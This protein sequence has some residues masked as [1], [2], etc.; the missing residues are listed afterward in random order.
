MLDHMISAIVNFTSTGIKAHQGLTL[1]R[2]SRQQD[3][4]FY[5][6]QQC[7]LVS[8]VSYAFNIKFWP[9]ALMY[10]LI[11]VISMSLSR[12]NVF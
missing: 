9:M 10:G 7:D 1:E 8:I 6:P 4:T 3:G 2:P 5:L 12:I 11:Q